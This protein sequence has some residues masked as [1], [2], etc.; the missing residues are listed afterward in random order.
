LYEDIQYYNKPYSFYRFSV[1]IKLQ[2]K[3]LLLLK[4]ENNGMKKTVL[5]FILI[6]ILQISVFTQI[7]LEESSNFNSDQEASVIDGLFLTHLKKNSKAKVLFI[8][9]TGKDRERIG[10]ILPYI[11]GVK[12]HFSYRNYETDRVSFV[13]AK[14]E[15]VFKREIWIINEGD[16]LPTFEEINY[17][18]GNLQEKFLFA[19]SCVECEPAVPH[20]SGEMIDWKLLAEILR[21]NPDHKVSLQIGKN[22]AHYDKDKM[23]SAKEYAGNLQKWFSEK[24]E[25]DKNRF[26]YK[27]VKEG[28]AKIYIIPNKK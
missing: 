4:R 3:A 23:V 1:K 28:S 15:N 8:I 18:F 21:K 16:N 11:K 5:I 7:K 12:T 2:H 14:G 17:D 27:V 20:L 6:S 9:Y 26:S 24:Y 13:V 25:I 19:S 22:S 10:N